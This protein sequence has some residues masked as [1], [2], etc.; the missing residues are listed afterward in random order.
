M[1]QKYPSFYFPLILT[2][3]HLLLYLTFYKTTHL[4]LQ[5]PQ[6]ISHHFI[7]LHS[8]FLVHR[9]K[10]SSS[11]LLHLQN[12]SSSFII[13][14]YFI[15]FLWY[16]EQ[17]VHF[18]FKS[19]RKFLIYSHPLFHSQSLEKLSHLILSSIYPLI[20]SSFCQV[21]SYCIFK[22]N[23]KNEFIEEIKEKG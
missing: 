13:F 22:H 7:L 14:F 10:N 19:P 20:L 17:K 23:E 6:K 21:I 2:T 9:M 16:T 15:L 8:L 18:S 3:S 11:F 12:D 5:K 1:R 4:F